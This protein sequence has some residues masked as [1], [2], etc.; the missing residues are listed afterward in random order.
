MM[1]NEMIQVNYEDTKFLQ[2]KEI[3]TNEFITLKD[4]NHK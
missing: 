1:G 3:E 4:E 2:A